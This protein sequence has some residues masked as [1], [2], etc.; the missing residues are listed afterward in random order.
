MNVDIRTEAAQFLFWEYINGIFVAVQ[1]Y[2]AYG[3]YTIGRSAAVWRRMM[4]KVLMSL[5]SGEWEHTFL[6]PPPKTGPVH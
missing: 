6:T 3:A 4:E 2:G 1:S 5:R